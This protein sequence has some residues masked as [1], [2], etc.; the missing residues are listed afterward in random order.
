MDKGKANTPCEFGVKVSIASTFKGNLIVG[1]RAFHGNPNDGHTLAE[2]MEQATILMQDSKTK[3]TA[4]FI[5]LG[6]RGV[7]ADNPGVHIVHRGKAQRI[8]EQEKKQLRRSQA[9]EPINGHLTAD[10]RLVRCHLKGAQGNRLHA[11]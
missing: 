7:D 10:H 6:Y 2:P 5:D 4:A 8:S 11:V 3:L 1:A 9:I